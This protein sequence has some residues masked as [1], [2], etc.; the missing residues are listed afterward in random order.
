MKL[1]RFQLSPEQIHKY[2]YIIEP[3]KWLINV[4][5]KTITDIYWGDYYNKK[6]RE[7]RRYY[8]HKS[9]RP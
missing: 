6:A 8:R 7:E 3:A 2:R 9:S 5:G 4:I 1:Q